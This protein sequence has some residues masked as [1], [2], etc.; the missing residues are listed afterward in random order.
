LQALFKNNLVKINRTH[1]LGTEF[2]ESSILSYFR[3]LDFRCKFD[4]KLNFDFLQHRETV[5]IERVVNQV[6]NIDRIEELK[7]DLLIIQKWDE[8]FVED[9]EENALRMNICI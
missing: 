3:S 6:N 1:T 7:S 8:K 5:D 2:T 9:L 4:D